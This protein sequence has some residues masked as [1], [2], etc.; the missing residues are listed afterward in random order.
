MPSANKIDQAKLKRELEEYGRKLRLM[1]H[2]Q[3][4]ERTFTAEKFRPKSSFNPSNKDT[5]IE[6][7]L[8]C[9]D[10]RLLDIN[11]LFKRYNNLTKNDCDVL[12]RLKDDPSI[13]IK[14]TGKSSVVVV[15]DREGYLKEAYK[16]LGDREVYEEV[17]NDPNVLINTMMKTLEKICLRGDLTSDTLHYFLVKDPKFARFNLL[18]K[19]HKCLHD[20]PVD[21]LFQTAALT[22][23]IYL[24][25]WTTICKH[26]L[27]G[28]NLILR[29]L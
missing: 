21:Q 29:T 14:G 18:P 1:W 2:F 11:I 4:D 10:K 15:W 7:Y 20:V 27:R 5:I 17:P 24:Y 3:N 16:Q 25:F 8:S 6:T 19:I 28:L 13:I 22:L 12:Y 26:L 9:L 23:R